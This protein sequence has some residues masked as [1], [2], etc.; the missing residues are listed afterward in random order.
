MAYQVPVHVPLPTY[1]WAA[2]NQMQE[3]CLFKCQLETWTWICKIKAEEKL[4][5]LLCILGRE[6][7][8]TMDRWVSAD[9]THKNDSMKFLDYIGS[10]L[11]DEISPWVHVY[12]LEDITKRSDES[13]NELLDWIHQ[14]A[15]RT[16]ISN[17]SD[18]V[19]EFK[20]QHRVIWVIPDTDI[21]LHKQLLKVNCDKRVWHLLEI[22]RTYYTVET[23]AAA[24]SVGH[25]VHAV[26]HTYQA[27]NSKPQM[28]YASCPNC[29]H[30]H[31]PSRHNC[32]AQDSACKGCGKKGHW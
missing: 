24:A 14:L 26:C 3:F 19:I 15:C 12:K 31:P 5:Y 11:D 21:E 9:E 6:G 23:G 22:C 17:G 8:A 30:Q 16:Q 28:S 32:P 13:I 2:S 7:Y 25:A 1:N 27:H 10:T 29:T 18:A 4:D 20:V